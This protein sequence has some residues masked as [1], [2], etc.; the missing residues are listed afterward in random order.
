MTRESAAAGETASTA[1]VAA[2][3]A[4]DA[5]FA[6]RAIFHVVCTDEN[7]VEKWREDVPNVVTAQGKLDLLNKYFTGSAYTAAWYCGLISSVSFSAVAVTDVAA[8]INGTNG[9]KEAGPTNA[10]ASG[11]NRATLTFGAATNVSNNGNIA[12]SSASSFTFTSGGTIKGMFACSTQ[13]K[14]ATTGILYN[15]V[16]FTG[17]DRAVVTSDVVNVSVSFTIT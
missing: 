16:A 14:D 11:A 2:P 17:G 10:P 13:A 7:G 3:G 9:W 5:M 6:P 8:Q 15:A 12:T 4:V 1:T